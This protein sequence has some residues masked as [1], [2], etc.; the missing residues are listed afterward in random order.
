M[1]NNIIKKYKNTEQGYIAL[2]TVVMITAIVVVIGLSTS[3]LSLNDLLSANAG[4]ENEEGIGL[5]EA[6][7]ED[8]LIRLNKNNAIPATLTL[9][10]GEGTC[11][12]TI[13]S[14]VGTS[15]DFTLVP[16]SQEYT[17]RIRIVA[18]RVTTVT[19]TSWLE[20]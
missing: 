6:C 2:I 14:Q 13:N 8:A 4:R 1:T 18:S 12:V 5:T 19:I 15:W 11:A 7:A 9:P 3:L 16:Q 10:N 20:Q 17:K